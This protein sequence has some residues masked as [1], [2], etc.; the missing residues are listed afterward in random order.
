MRVNNQEV[1]FNMNKAM[2]VPDKPKECCSVQLVNN[3]VHEHCQQSMIKDPL[4]ALLIEGKGSEVKEVQEMVNFLYASKKVGLP[5]QSFEALDLSSRASPPLK[6]S[7]EEPPALELKP[8]PSHLKYV[9][10]KE[11]NTLLV[12]IS[13]PLVIDQEDKLVGVLKKFKK[14]TGWSITY[15]K[16]ISPSICMYKILLEDGHKKSV[17][18]QRRFESYLAGSSEKGNCENGWMLTLY[19]PSQIAHG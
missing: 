11:S 17:E 19:I 15:I 6:P 3:V 10:L 7:I 5:K 2:K 16:K 13:S 1:T 9:Y 18:N 12:I 14:A 4:E 8:F